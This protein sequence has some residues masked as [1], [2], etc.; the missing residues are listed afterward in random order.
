MK[1]TIKQCS[2]V[3][4]SLEDWYKDMIG[5]EFEVLWDS[6]YYYFVKNDLGANFI[7]KKDV[8]TDD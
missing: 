2:Q 3:G 7:N 8:I 4:D 1:I 6:D 5:R